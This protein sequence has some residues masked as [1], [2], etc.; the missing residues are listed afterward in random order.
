[1]RAIGGTTLSAFGVPG[2]LVDPLLALFS[3]A[4]KLEENNDWSAAAN[5]AAINTTTTA[6]GTFALAAGSKDSVILMTLPP[7]SYTAQVSGVGDT[8]GVSSVIRSVRR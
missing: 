4:T 5:A 6:L 1:V 2:V 8:T 7:G 3:G